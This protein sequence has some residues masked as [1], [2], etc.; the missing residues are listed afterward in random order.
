[1]AAYYPV[2]VV[3]G[4]TMGTAAWDLGQR[5]IPALVLQQFGHVQEFG[6]HGG[7]TRVIRHAYAE[8]SHYVPLVLRADALW[9]DLE[10]ESGQQLLH[11]S[12]VL[13][14]AASGA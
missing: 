9:E 4:D 7:H 5:G 1:M 11:R 8:G 14:L 3:G 2:I 12:D 10:A 6:S 13:E